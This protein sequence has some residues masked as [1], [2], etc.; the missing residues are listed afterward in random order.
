M[1]DEKVIEHCKILCNLVDSMRYM[2]SEGFESIPDSKTWS[3]LQ[4][5]SDNL[6]EISFREHEPKPY[7]G[8]KCWSQTHFEVVSILTLLE[9]KP[10]N[11]QPFE[12]LSVRKNEGTTGVWE[13]AEAITNE[14]EDQNEGREW[15]GE[16]YE[17]IEAF[18]RQKLTEQ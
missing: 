13:L 15:D 10:E 18:V 4:D 16:F 3:K 11:E 14:F 7:N 1:K 12:L 5:I 9:Q 6:Y 17:E 8:L 2:M